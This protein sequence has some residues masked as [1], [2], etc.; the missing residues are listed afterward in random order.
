MYRFPIIICYPSNLLP[1]F[2]GYSSTYSYPLYRTRSHSPHSLCIMYISWLFSRLLSA[3]MLRAPTTSLVPFPSLNPNWLSP[4]HPSASP[5]PGTFSSFKS[6]QVFVYSDHLWH[7][8]RGVNCHFLRS[9]RQQ[10]DGSALF[11]SWCTSFFFMGIRIVCNKS[12]GHFP[13]VWIRSM[14]IL[15]NPLVPSLPDPLI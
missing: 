9:M 5:W 15:A 10:A 1:S 4:R 6:S 8:R 11:A 13:V 7:K 2:S 12:Y 14:D 3:S